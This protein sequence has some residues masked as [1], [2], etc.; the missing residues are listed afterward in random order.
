MSAAAKK[1]KL[2]PVIS[3]GEGWNYRILAVDDEVEIASLYKN[4]L[5][6]KYERPG[7]QSSRGN[8]HVLPNA[9]LKASQEFPFEV[10]VAYSYEE[11]MQKFNS[12]RDSGRPYAMGFFDVRLGG[13]RDGVQLVKEMFSMDPQFMAVFVTAHNDRGL[14]SFQSTLGAE[15]VDRWDYVTKPFNNNE[16]VQ[17]ARARVTLWN[18]RTDREGHA[19]ELE[20]LN[21]KVQESE[22]LTSV[23]AVARGVAHEFGNLL[24][25]I[26]GNAEI[27]RNK[28]PEDMRAALDKIINASQVASD[29]LDRFHNLS[30]HKSQQIGKNNE[31]ILSLARGALDLLAH[32]FRKEGV[33]IVLSRQE[34]VFAHVHGTSLLQVFVNLF[35]NAVHAMKHS[36]PR[37]I[38]L[39]IYEENENVVLKIRDSGPGVAKEHLA[40]ISEPFYTTKGADGTGLG[41]SICKEIVEIDHRGEFLLSNHPQGGF[42][43]KITIPKKQEG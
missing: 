43:I 33:E 42:E 30:D 11:A 13:P 23:A 16:V 37:K 18:L 20:E 35:I 40:R 32:Q 5:E 21:R 25:Q 9:N 1:I 39:D 7:L 12:A 15:Q 3:V 19:L 29:I 6:R 27:S 22:R 8:V 31:S 38:Y 14:D 4:I 17:Q 10:D 2:D 36:H 24:M 34:N 28:S 41:L 26:V